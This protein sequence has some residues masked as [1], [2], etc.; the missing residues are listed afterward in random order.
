MAKKEITISRN[1]LVGIVSIVVFVAV[2]LYFA[3][4]AK[5]EVAT[6]N[7]DNDHVAI[8]GYDTVAYF[9]DGK[10][11][12][13]SA[14]FEYKWEDARWLFANARHRDMFAKHP[15]SFAPQFGGYCALG[16]SAGEYADADPEAWT[17][18]E[19][20]LYFQKTKDLRDIWRKAPRALIGNGEHN[21]KNNRKQLRI[22]L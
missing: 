14:E 2:G 16:L 7:M 4:A 1:L 3:T 15:E 11:T 20:K 8:H 21:W 22:N 12:K 6:Y 13:G 5:T 17:I 19:G 18:V 10:A 9:T